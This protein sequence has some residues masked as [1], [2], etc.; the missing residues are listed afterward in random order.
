[1]LLSV[2]LGTSLAPMDSSVNA[3]F[4]AITNAFSLSVTDIRWVII[5]YVLTYASLPLAF[6]RVGDLFGHR[7]VFLLG[8][9]WSA[10]AYLGCALATQFHWLLLARINQGIGT[11]LLL[12]TAPALVTL[13]MP[14]EQR[15]RGIA[16][17]VSAFAA[18]QTIGPLLGGALVQWFDWPAVFWMRIPIAL[19]AI[20]LTI[21]MIPTPPK[22]Q[23]R[24]AFNPLSGIML[25][26]GLAA[27]LLMLANKDQ[28]LKSC[29]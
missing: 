26:I 25:S 11:A 13:S 3:A 14:P 15:T 8:L 29:P 4:P 28:T 23:Q 21:T 12:A 1:M 22:P 2:A 18:S 19:V 16:L 24:V 27:T 6:G 17:Y 10:I 5:V 7:R 9:I 20:V